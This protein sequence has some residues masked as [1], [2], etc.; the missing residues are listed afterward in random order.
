M[1]HLTIRKL[2]KIGNKS[3]AVV[4]P[5]QWIDYYGLKYGDKVEVYTNGKIIIKPLK[6]S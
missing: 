6:K 1:P 4:I 2:V 5:Y 3:L